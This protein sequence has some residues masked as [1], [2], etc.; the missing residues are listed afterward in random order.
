[1]LHKSFLI[2]PIILLALLAGVA[3]TSAD[4]PGSVES[5]IIHSCV[6]KSGEIHILL[7]DGKKKKDAECKKKDIQ[8]NWNARGVQGET[9]P[10]GPSGPTGSAGPTVP[11]V[12][13]APAVPA[14][15]AV[16]SSDS[17]SSTSCV[18]RT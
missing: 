8:L 10:A 13:Q 11:P 3:G 14:A 9:G 12:L 6:K 17:S 18:R 5:G 7:D 1:M 16:A 15:L 4:T 2:L